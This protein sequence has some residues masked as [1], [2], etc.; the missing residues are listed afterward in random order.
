MEKRKRL[1]GDSLGWGS[2][3]SQDSLVAV[4]RVWESKEFAEAIFMH[5]I[6]RV[7]Q[8]RLAPISFRTGRV[9]VIFFEPDAGQRDM[10]P[11][12]AW[13]HIWVL[14]LGNEWT[15]V[16]RNNFHNNPQESV[17]KERERSA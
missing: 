16:E 11:A 14:H 4:F 9:G 5:G 12:I 17:G 6:D 3:G 8:A 1:C 10:A 2:S 7:G 13:T 15:W